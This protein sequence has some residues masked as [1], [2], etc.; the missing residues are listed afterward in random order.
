M[1]VWAREGSE[2]TGRSSSEVA[3]RTSP[4]RE[5]G[6]P[7]AKTKFFA[8]GCARR[9]CGVAGVCL[10]QPLF[11]VFVKHNVSLFFNNS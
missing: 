4:G 1:W 10:F 7:E 8:G 5:D 9:A 11:S 6:G 3:P 2:T